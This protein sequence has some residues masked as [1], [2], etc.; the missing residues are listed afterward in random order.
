MSEGAQRVVTA[1]GA[2]LGD[3]ASAEHDVHGE[4]A[5]SLV[6]TIGDPELCSLI[7]PA[8]VRHG[9]LVRTYA[10][11]EELLDSVLFTSLA[12]LALAVGGVGGVRACSALRRAGFRQ[13][14]IVV[15]ADA[16]PTLRALALDAGADDC[17]GT[18]FDTAELAA[19]VDALRRR[20]A[21]ATDEAAA[22]VGEFGPVR[23]DWQGVGAWIRGKY[24]RLTP[25]RFR[26][27]ALLVRRR[28]APVFVEEI[29]ADVQG[30]HR[31]AQAAENLI[32][33]L[34]R[35]IGCHGDLIRRQRGGGIAL[36]L[37]DDPPVSGARPLSRG[38]AP[39]RHRSKG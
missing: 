30:G 15:S 9:F 38:Q 1:P 10:G 25:L 28:G 3:A 36:A 11:L 13:G 12:V 17:I 33:L 4:G 37:G 2:T 31:S 6:A 32:F 23:L 16:D 39:K 5:R 14:I 8:M 35:D 20:C 27:L 18:P 19:R 22:E 7:R 26:L 24:S 21:W 34:R 29:A